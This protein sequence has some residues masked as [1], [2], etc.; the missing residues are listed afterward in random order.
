MRTRLI[1]NLPILLLLVASS[2]SQAQRVTKLSLEKERVVS[3]TPLKLLIDFTS[4]GSMWCGLQVNWGDG[5][6]RD[7][8]IGDDNLKTSP[9]AIEHAYDASGNFLI[10]VKGQFLSRGLKSAPACDVS[11]P[12]LRLAV[13]ETAAD[14]PKETE[15]R[16]TAEGAAAALG[17]AET[18][19]LE[20]EAHQ[21]E[22]NQKQLEL[23][24]RELDI[25]R[26]ELEMREEAMRLQQAKA[27]E[28]KG[29][30]SGAPLPPTQGQKTT[31]ATAPKSAASASKPARKPHADGF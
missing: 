3:R 27:N 1:R 13:L 18:A 4:G 7:L 11:T 6:I 26:K 31:Q 24:N 19:R 22:L 12:P 30:Q 20:A 9:I 10:S 25:K 17:R 14:Q 8:R 16:N 2:V 21:R 28:A 15:R 29:M 23:A 5:A